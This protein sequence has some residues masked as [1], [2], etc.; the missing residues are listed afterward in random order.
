MKSVKG[1]FIFAIGTL[2]GTFIGAQIAKKKY[3]EI[4][5][6]EIITKERS[7]ANMKESFL[8]CFFIFVSSFNYRGKAYSCK[9]QARIPR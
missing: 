9:L 5:N 6:E 3:E 2:T 8:K 7:N 1:I 4:A